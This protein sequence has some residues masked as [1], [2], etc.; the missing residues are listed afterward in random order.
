MDRRYDGDRKVPPDKDRI[1][2]SIGR[3]V[4]AHRQGFAGT[5]NID[6][7]A[8]HTSEAAHIQTAAKGTAFP[9][10]DHAPYAC[11]RGEAISR[12]HKRIEHGVVKRIELLRTYKANIGDAVTNL[13]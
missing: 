9:R 3:T 4:R 1:L 12:S 5:W 11:V 7:A 13:D 6:V 10:Q 8:A 2:F